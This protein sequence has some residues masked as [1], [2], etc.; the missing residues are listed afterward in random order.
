MS[1][2]GGRRDRCNRVAVLTSHSHH[3]SPTQATLLTFKPAGLIHLHGRRDSASVVRF[4][5]SISHSHHC[6]PTQAMLLTFKPTG[7][8]HLYGRYNS[9]SVVCLCQSIDQILADLFPK[10]VVIVTGCSS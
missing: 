8:I 10:G 5:Q 7:L 4:G 3:C 6:S 2:T 9:A 1:C